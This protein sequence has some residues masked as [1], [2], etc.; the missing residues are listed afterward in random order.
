M[1]VRNSELY[2]ALLEAGVSKESASKAA[3]SVAEFN[4]KIAEV[5]SDLRL[6]K[7][8]VGFSLAGTAGVLWAI[9]ALSTQVGRLTE[10]VTRIVS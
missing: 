6:L 10:A 9:I 3:E 7:W 5:R 4:G 2:D 1:T 8:M